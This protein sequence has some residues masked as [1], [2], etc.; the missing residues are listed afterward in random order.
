[1]LK[2]DTTIAKIQLGFQWSISV[3]DSD[4]RMLLASDFATGVDW[5]SYNGLVDISGVVSSVTSAG[6]SMKITNGFGSLKSPAVVTGLTSFVVIDEATPGSPLSP[7]ITE[8]TSIP[9]LYVF[10]G[11]TLTSGP[12]YQCSLGAAVLGFDDSKLEAVE[13]NF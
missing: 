13:I 5:L 11:L 2:L 12:E 8:S 7:T 6:F 9:G 4:V 3:K 1:M 10:S